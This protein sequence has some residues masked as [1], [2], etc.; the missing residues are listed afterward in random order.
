MKNPLSTTLYYVTFNME[1]ETNEKQLIY[2]RSAVQ[3]K[4]RSRSAE[5]PR[6]SGAEKRKNRK[7]DKELTMNS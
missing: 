2:S 5:S 7:G 3:R 1:T 4:N 6:L